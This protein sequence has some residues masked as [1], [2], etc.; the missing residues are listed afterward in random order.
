MM[1]ALP[2]SSSGLERSISG[3]RTRRRPTPS[4]GTRR[5]SA[6]G[7]TRSAP[8]PVT[9]PARPPPQRRSPS[10]SATRQ[11]LRWAL[12]SWRRMDSMRGRAPRQQIRPGKGNVGSVS[13]PVWSAAGR[14]G[15]ALSFDGVNDWVTV[16]DSNSLDLT[17]GMTVEAWVRPSALGGWRTVAFKERSG[18]ARVR[19]VRGSGRR[20]S[21]GRDVRRLGAERD[22]DRCAAAECL[23]PPGDDLRRVALAALRERR[24]GIL[25]GCD[26]CDGGLDWGVAPRWQQRLGRVV[27]RPDRRGAGL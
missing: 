3:A 14:Y 27:R 12:A 4:P 11:G 10:R 13:G 2:A 21:T 6:T 9:P 24:V 22:R 25:D 26:G 18:R 20:P 15:S 8:S 23:V 17:T 1:L 16:A 7:A 19:V 5:P